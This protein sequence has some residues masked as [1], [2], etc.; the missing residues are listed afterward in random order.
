MTTGEIDRAVESMIRDAGCV[1]SFKGYNG[2]PASA[3]ISVNEEVV[4]GIPGS[5]VLVDGDI[6]G[7][8]VGLIHDGWHAD[9]AETLAVGEISPAGGA[10]CCGSP[11][12]ACGSPSPRSRPAGG[13]R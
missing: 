4:H 5:R 3:C 11:T 8:D 1:P 6:V 13:S 10:N 7:I 9:S 2:F 12:S